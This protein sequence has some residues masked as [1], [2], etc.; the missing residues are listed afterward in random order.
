M[1]ISIKIGEKYV[2]TSD[3][4]QFILNQ[5]AVKGDKSNQAGE[6]YLKAV[7]YYYSIDLL[8]KALMQRELR[9]SDAT[10]L[11]Q[12]RQILVTTGAACVRAMQGKE[13]P[14]AKHPDADLCS[15]CC[16]TG[17]TEGGDDICEACTG[18]G[19]DDGVA[20]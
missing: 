20:Q 9:Q 12:C 8:V 5:V 16:G 2:I 4:L 7:G 6:T 14:K 11:E 1:S 10:S 15:V 18:F 13:Q 19:Y 3:N 17:S